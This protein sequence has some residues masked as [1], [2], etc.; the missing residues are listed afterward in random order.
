MVEGFVIQQSGTELFVDKGGKLV[1]KGEAL[2]I[3][4]RSVAVAWVKRNAKDGQTFKVTPVEGVPDIYRTDLDPKDWSERKDDDMSA[5]K[6]T[7]AKAAETKGKSRR[8]EFKVGDKTGAGCTILKVIENPTGE[9]GH[10]RQLEIKC[11]HSGKS[12]VINTQDAHQTKFHPDCRAEAKRLEKAGKLG[13]SIA[14]AP[15][16]KAPAKAPAKKA[17]AK[18]K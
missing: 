8:K 4:N 17:A 3:Y 10:T 15:A 12:F 6:K 11:L 18:K 7:P 1:P 13:E 9:Y 14:K 16:K 5:A 2:V